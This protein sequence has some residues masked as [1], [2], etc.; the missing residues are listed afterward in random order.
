MIA[1]NAWTIKMPLENIPK[2]QQQFL[3]TIINNMMQG[4]V[5]VDTKGV[6][7][8]FNGRAENIF[9]YSAAEIIEQNANILMPN[10]KE[11][12]SQNSIEEYLTK[13][14]AR[15]VGISRD[16]FG[17]KKTG[18]IFPMNLS[19]T[20]TTLGKDIFYIALILDRTE[21]IEREETL[22]KAKEDA[23][24][25]NQT[26][27]DFLANMS[28]E[29]RTPL[30]SILGL[31]RMFLEDENFNGESRSMAET[32]YKAATNL[33]ENVNDILDISKIESGNMI[34]E[35]ISFNF[36]DVVDNVVETMLPIAK[37]KGIYLNNYYL[38]DNI[39][40]TIGDP[41]RLNLILTNFISNAM[42]YMHDGEIDIFMNGEDDI[43]IITKT[44][45]LSN[46][47]IEIH[48]AVN[49]TGIGISKDKLENIF[50]KFVQAD[51][52]TTRKF[53]GTGLGLAITKELVEKMGGTIGVD[54]I[55]GEGSSF[56][57]KIPFA[58]TNKRDQ[59]GKNASHKERRKRKRTRTETRIPLQKA[60]I[61]VAEDHLLNQD[62]IRRLLKRLG[63]E[64]F[65]ICDNGI[66]AQIAFEEHHYDLILMDCHMP[67]QN[68]YETT[69]AI[70]KASKDNAQNIPIIAMTADAMKGTKEQCLACGMDDYISKPINLEE[71]KN[72]LEQWIIF[73]HD[74]EAR[75]FTPPKNPQSKP[76]DINILKEYAE[77]DDDIGVF[78]DI[79]LTQS[80]DSLRLLKENCTDGENIEWIE[81]A[82]KLKGGAGM[83]GAKK[84]YEICSEAQEMINAS[85]NQRKIIMDSILQEFKAVKNYLKEYL[86]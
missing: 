21:Q 28:H 46:N 83:F 26:K 53:G 64:N 10:P 86:N 51:L 70:R 67:E 14:S 35:E 12:A 62:F 39:P 40:Q 19:I 84:L 61:L 18:K 63:F 52:S 15:H 31:T 1:T 43:E 69:T 78:A 74:K 11:H 4:V 9:L 17:R 68:G 48:C 47:K 54:S 79:F 37:E 6:I 50:D 16:V 81:S 44:S 8:S 49:D 76:V 33:L 80:E 3:N 22:K 24:K 85:A 75:S 29:L 65:D 38:N 73:T 13:N 71:F 66:I 27:S 56:W 72:I 5:I 23:D 82:H 32:I 58:I 2:Q 59:T 41:F 34:L 36:K 30:N 42:K 45:H 60:R 20:E 25:A 77:T 7:K 55:V 57:F